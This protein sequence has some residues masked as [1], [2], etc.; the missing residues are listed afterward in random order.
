MYKK[1]K[2]WYYSLITEKWA[3]ELNKKLTEEMQMVNKHIKMLF[4][5]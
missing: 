1:K 5:L 2:K 3:E 4:H